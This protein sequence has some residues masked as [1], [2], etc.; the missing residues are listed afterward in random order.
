MI[1]YIRARLREKSTWAGLLA[2][3]LAIALLIVPLKV[4]AEA[5]AQLSNNIQW[6]ITA[7]FASGL[8][9]IIWHRKV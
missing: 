4:E 3:V 2:I 1:E 9:G 7:L 6:L 8:G 5:A